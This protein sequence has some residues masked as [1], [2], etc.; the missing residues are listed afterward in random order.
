MPRERLSMRKIKDVLRL[1][2]ESGLSTRQIGPPTTF[3]VVGESFMLGS[4]RYPAHRT[5]NR[6]FRVLVSGISINQATIRRML[7]GSSRHYML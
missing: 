5:A 1:R 3:D 2:F 4:R 7:R 6:D